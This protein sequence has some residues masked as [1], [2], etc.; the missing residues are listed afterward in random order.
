MYKNTYI[1]ANTPTR[2]RVAPVSTIRSKFSNIY[3]N[4]PNL[5]SSDAARLQ[6]HA[7]ISPSIST[8]CDR[9]NYDRGY[10]ALLYDIHLVH[11][12]AS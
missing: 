5:F 7:T 8:S 10:R 9:S 11:K 4:I 12:G 6:R 1:Y 3:I 2:K